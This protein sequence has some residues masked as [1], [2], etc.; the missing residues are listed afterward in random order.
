MLTILTTLALAA[1]W[2]HQRVTLFDEAIAIPLTA[3]VP[4]PVHPGILIG[5][6]VWSSGTEHLEHRLQLDLGGY[7]HRPIEHALFV[8]PHWQGT[9]R[10]VSRLGL[11]LLGGAGYKH[12]FYAAPTWVQ[13]D[14]AWVRRRR[15]GHPE[16][17]GQLGLGVDVRLD[18]HW[19]L[20]VQHRGSVDGP[21]SPE[22]APA[23]FHSSTHLGV[24]V[25]R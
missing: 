4:T 16:V 22:L 19:A 21:F 8:L 23:M 17:T 25:R 10:P 5:T 14:G 6:S 1:P 11:S 20:L 2:Q 13:R 7:L 12:A 9:W 24:E 15:A 18:D 3:A